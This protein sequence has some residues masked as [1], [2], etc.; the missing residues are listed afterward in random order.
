MN[1]QDFVRANKFDQWIGYIQTQETIRIG[2]GQSLLDIGCGIG[3]YTPIFLERFSYVTGLDSSVD[4]LTVAKKNNDIVNYT[5]GDAETFSLENLY[6]TINLNMI[7]EHVNDPVQVLINCKKH[8]SEKGVIICQVPNSNSVTRRL[9]VIMGV[10]DSIKHMSEKEISF[11]GH[12]RTYTLSTLSHD[13]EKAG[14]SVI[15][16]G[17]LVYKPLPNDELLKISSD[18]SKEWIDK[19]LNAL[20]DFG[21]DKPEDCAVSYTVCTH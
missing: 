19:F 11:F 12:Q 21:R 6:D 15:Q 20:L 8:L 16:K 3:Q 17:G 9:G 2:R 14:L 10:I 1:N 7:L 18:K 13:C 4:C 5:L